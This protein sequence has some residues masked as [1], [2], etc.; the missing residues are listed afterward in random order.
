MWNKIKNEYAAISLIVIPYIIFALLRF[1]IRIGEMRNYIPWI[2]YIIIHKM[3]YF[4]RFNPDLL[5][6]N[7]AAAKEETISINKQ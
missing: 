4:S 6:I 2:Q 3:L 1:G 7:D 5:K